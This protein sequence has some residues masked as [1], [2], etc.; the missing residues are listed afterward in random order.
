MS[1]FRLKSPGG[2]DVN[3]A[4]GNPVPNAPMILDIAAIQ[5]LCRE[6]P[7]ARWDDGVIT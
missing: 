6:P 7:I 3:V 1:Y 5:W 2:A 4:I